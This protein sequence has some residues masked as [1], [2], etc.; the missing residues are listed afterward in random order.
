MFSNCSLQISVLGI[1]W[2]GSRQDWGPTGSD[3]GKAGHPLDRIQARRSS[4]II[5]G[6][7]RHPKS[8][9]CHLLASLRV[10]MS[11]W[12]PWEPNLATGFGFKLNLFYT[13]HV[14]SSSEHHKFHVTFGRNRD[15]KSKPRKTGNYANQPAWFCPQLM[16]MQ[17]L[18]AQSKQA[19]SMTLETSGF[20]GV[21][22]CKI[23]FWE[24]RC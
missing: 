2:I 13:Q 15:T 14:S 19:K 22:E 24:I 21:G 3:P 23:W 5:S 11:H 7:E 4:D 10:W 18:Y 17:T 9:S 6:R 16:I 1:H 8:A 20:S 12:Q